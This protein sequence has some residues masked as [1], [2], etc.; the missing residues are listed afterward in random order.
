M[1]LCPY[2]QAYSGVGTKFGNKNQENYG[3]KSIIKNKKFHDSTINLQRNTYTTSLILMNRNSSWNYNKIGSNIVTSF[4]Q[5]IDTSNP[6]IWIIYMRYLYGN[7][8]SIE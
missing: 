7:L 3:L 8:S 6:F 1:K 5:N 2:L 4:K